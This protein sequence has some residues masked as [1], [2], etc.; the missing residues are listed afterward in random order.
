MTLPI[1]AGTPGIRIVLG[2]CFWQRWLLGGAR[3]FPASDAPKKS[4]QSLCLT[5]AGGR[6]LLRQE[7]AAT[8]LDFDGV[9]S[10]N[11][12]DCADRAAPRNLCKGCRVAV[13]TG[14]SELAGHGQN[15]QQLDDFS[16]DKWDS[17]FY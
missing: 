8:W 1:L 2:P 4:R 11:R 9:H 15:S 16:I 3:R 6:Y 17:Y 14:T 7:A 12:A 5:G 13:D 10:A